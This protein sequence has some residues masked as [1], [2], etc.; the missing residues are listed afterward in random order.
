MTTASPKPDRNWQD[1]FTSQSLALGFLSKAIYEPP[2]HEFLQPLIENDLFNYWPLAD[3]NPETQQGLDRLQAFCQTWT[4]D[5]LAD[6]RWD[7]Q[8][9]F[10]GPGILAAPWESVFLSDEHLLFERQTLQVREVYSRFGLQ[11]PKLNSEPDDH[12]GL[13]LAFMVHLCSLGLHAIEN[14]QSAELAKIVEVQR[15]FMQEHLL[16]WAPRCLARVIEQAKTDYYRGVG[17]LGLGTLIEA[18]RTLELDMPIETVAD[19]A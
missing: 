10:V 5:S 17:H 4:P 18:A 16:R 7:Y 19:P 14:D 11:A 12:L 3:S 9:L 13:E 15:E 1:I 2:T 8:C 6:L